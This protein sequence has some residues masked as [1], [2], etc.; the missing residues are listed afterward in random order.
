MSECQTIM[1]PSG[2][3]ATLRAPE[4]LRGRDKSIVRRRAAAAQAGNAQELG[5]VIEE[6]IARVLVQAWDLP[7]R[8]G[9]GLPADDQEAWDALTIADMDAIVAAARP[10]IPVIFPAPPTPDDA[11]TPGSPTAPTSG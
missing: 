6:E 3:T 7:Y 2:G 4:M 1:L 10:A 11:D 9:A 5:V 8:A